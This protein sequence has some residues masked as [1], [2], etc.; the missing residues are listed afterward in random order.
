MGAKPGV[1]TKGVNWGNLG[2]RERQGCRELKDWGGKDRAGDR[3]RKRQKLGRI[4]WWW[5]VLG[6]EKEEEVLF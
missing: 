4:R 2:V 1:G 6:E 5:R 3:S